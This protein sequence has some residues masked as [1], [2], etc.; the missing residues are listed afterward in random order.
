MNA[1]LLAV[2]LGAPP[3]ELVCPAAEVDLGEKKC[4][5]RLT[6]TFTVT[7]PATNRDSIVIAAVNSGCGCV[8]RDDTIRRL[9]PGESAAI[10]ITVNTLTQAAGPNTW[11][12]TVWYKNEPEGGSPNIP[13]QNLSLT[14]KAKLVREVT[15]SPPSLAFSTTS[16]AKQT[17]TVTDRRAKPLTVTKATTTA[18]HLTAAVR[19]AAG[20]QEI[21]LVLAA[22]SPLGE[23]DEA[24]TLVTDDPEYA[25]LRVP[26]RVTKRPAADVSATPAAVN[27]R[28][29]AGQTDLSALV[30]LRAG[31]KAVAVAK[32]EC[33]HPSVRVKWSE[34]SGPVATVRVVVA[35]AA[36]GQ[37]DVRVTL[38]EPE[39]KVVTVPVT[40]SGR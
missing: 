19:T 20:G 17:L 18:P 29:A 34:G 3:V 30:Q 27:L 14:L 15:V 28:F 39:G 16:G 40:W 1:I 7:N 38:A 21:D 5:P 37:A 36:A 32:A 25:E 22:D 31:G 11:H 4:G 35:A 2:V 13:N 23:T 26:V 9:A 8:R 10:P 24:V 33:D 12:A 6:H